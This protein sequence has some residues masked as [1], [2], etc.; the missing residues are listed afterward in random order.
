M[1]SQCGIRY[2]YANKPAPTGWSGIDHEAHVTACLR[3]GRCAACRDRLCATTPARLELAA[4]AAGHPPGLAAGGNTQSEF[5]AADAARR[6][7]WRYRQQRARAPGRAARGSV[8]TARPGCALNATGIAGA[9][10]DAIEASRH[11][12]RSAISGTT[13]R[14]GSLIIAIKHSVAE[15][16]PVCPYP[17][18]T[19]FFLHTRWRAKSA[20][21]FAGA[22]RHK[23]SIETRNW[24]RHA[25]DASRLTRFARAHCSRERPSCNSRPPRRRLPSLRLQR[26]RKRNPAYGAR[27]SRANAR[28]AQAAQIQSGLVRSAPR[29]PQEHGNPAREPPSVAERCPSCQANGDTEKRLGASP[30]APDGIAPVAAPRVQLRS[31]KWSSHFFLKVQPRLICSRHN[32]ASVDT[33]T[34]DSVRNHAFIRQCMHWPPFI[35]VPRV[36]AVLAF[37]FQ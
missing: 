21:G 25:L 8:A 32:G 18:D 9:P 24:R 28:R 31:N 6:P 13:G 12:R 27:P 14:I 11:R 19:G 34:T 26:R 7:A 23:G 22:P 16:I 33:R 4:G 3:L 2:E 30:T 1:L 36:N 17:R 35:S 15:V 10:A 20:A 37:C 29:C 5:H